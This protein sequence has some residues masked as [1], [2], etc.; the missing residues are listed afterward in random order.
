LQDNYDK[1]KAA[2]AE[3]IAIS[4]DSVG[5]TKNTIDKVGLNFVVLADNDR[6][7]INA[8]NVVDPANKRIARPASFVI[9][10]DGT[11]AWTFLDVRLGNRVPTAEILDE[12]GKL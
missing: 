7:V 5:D 1:F 12:L 2:G 4:S 8:Y 9:K 6:E 10:K 11:V 3:L